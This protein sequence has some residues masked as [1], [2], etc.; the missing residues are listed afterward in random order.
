MYP[1]LKLQLWKSGIR[2]NR[3]ARLVGV[4]ETVLSRLVN[5]FRE[6]TPKLRDQIATVLNC[7]ATWLFTEDIELNVPAMASVGT[8]GP[9]VARTSEA[10]RNLLDNN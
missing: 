7:D 1:N 4:D 3:L 8:A 6:P 5:G 9:L 2:Q 10:P